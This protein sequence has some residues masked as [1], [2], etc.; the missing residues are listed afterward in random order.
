MKQA[1]SI[2]AL[3]STT[4]AGPQPTH[5]APT[6]TWTRYA[7]IAKC[8][9]DRAHLNNVCFGLK[10]GRSLGLIDAKLPDDELAQRKGAYYDDERELPAPEGPTN[11]VVEVWNNT[12]TY[13]FIAAAPAA[14]DEARGNTIY[15]IAPHTDATGPAVD[16]FWWI[17]LHKM[18]PNGKVT[19]ANPAHPGAAPTYPTTTY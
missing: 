1:F 3:A 19:G 7:S 12:D 15:N 11:P 10:D 17:F 18:D 2:L 5:A 16:C 6:D 4:L 8:K 13:T 14:T 9:S